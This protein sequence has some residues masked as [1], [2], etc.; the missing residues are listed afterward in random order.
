MRIYKTIIRPTLIY[1]CESWTLSKKNENALN[2][3]QRKILRRILGPI[4][5]NGTWRH[6]YNMEIYDS[7][8]DS[9]IST[10]IR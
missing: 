9:C 2:S 4:N 6:R 7:F 5:E 3:F 8:K 1:G 10:A